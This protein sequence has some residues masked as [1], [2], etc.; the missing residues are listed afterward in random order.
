MAKA[1]KNKCIKK[2][3]GTAV[4]NGLIVV[5]KRAGGGGDNKV[6]VELLPSLLKIWNCKSSYRCLMNI[7]YGFGAL[8]V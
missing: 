1:E 7:L 6:P 5:P 2:Q 8:S 3:R 4:I